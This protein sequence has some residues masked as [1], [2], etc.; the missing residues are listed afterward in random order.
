MHSA[1][2][3]LLLLLLAATVDARFA[4]ASSAAGRSLLQTVDCTR[5][6]NW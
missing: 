6:A 3:P 5:I 4:P 2:A 1:T